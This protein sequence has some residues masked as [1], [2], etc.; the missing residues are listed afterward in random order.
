M[1][2]VSD[3]RPQP[4]LTFHASRAERDLIHKGL[5]MFSNLYRLSSHIFKIVQTHLISL[6]KCLNPDSEIV[7]CEL[8][9]R[10]A[11]GDDIINFPCLLGMDD[12]GGASPR[13]GVGSGEGTGMGVELGS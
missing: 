4:S 7:L 9:V 1:V 8:R 12:S 6:C 5:H 2:V 13:V 10:S 3:T 11:G